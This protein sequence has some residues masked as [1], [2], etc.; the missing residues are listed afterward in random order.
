V[1]GSYSAPVEGVRHAATAAPEGLF[2]EPLSTSDPSGNPDSYPPNLN[3]QSISS[4]AA[5][6]Y[7]RVVMDFTGLQMTLTVVLV[8]TAATV[9]V[10][11]E[12][13]RKQCPRPEPQR[14]KTR[15]HSVAHPPRPVWINPAPLEFAP[16]RKLAAERPLEPRVGIATPSRPPVQLRERESVTVQMASPSTESHLPAFTIDTALW[17]RLVSSQPKQNLISSAD[18][19]PEPT[20]NTQHPRGMIQQPVLDKLLEGQEPFTGLVVSIGI[21]DSDSSMW[22]SQGLMQSVGSHIAGLLKEQDFSCRT[23]YDEFVMVCQGEQGAQSQR[24]LNHIS[25]RLWDYQLRGIGSCSILF[26]WGG[27]QVQNQP[28]AEAIASATERMRE[29][30]RTG[31]SLAHRQAV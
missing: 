13:R 20:D 31:N 9:V 21:N 4:L 24:R 7:N 12:Q 19:D 25:E 11:L 23:A 30:K 18:S 10:F 2:L 16:A 6:L 5:R 27:V 8:L 3:Q 29:T 26:S 22:H 17:E 28:L 15:I 14:I 1:N